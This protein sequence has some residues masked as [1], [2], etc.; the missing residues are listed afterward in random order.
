MP[1]LDLA[2]IRTQ[3]DQLVALLDKRSLRARQLYREIA[4]VLEGSAEA[5]QLMR[6]EQEIGRLDFDAARQTLMQLRGDSEH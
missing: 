3:I 2:S 1:T 6:L 4:G 5:E